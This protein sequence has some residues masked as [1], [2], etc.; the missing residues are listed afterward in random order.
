MNT[1]Q[2]EHILRLRC[3][4]QFL[5]VYP[6]DKLPKT[7]PPKRPLIL[8]CNTDPHDRPGQH[9]IVI[10]IDIHSVGEHFDSFGQRPAKTFQDFMR[11]HCFKWICNQRQIQSAASRFCG[12]YCVF[13]SL[14][15][16]IGYNMNAIV[17]CFSSDT[18][19]ND[20]MAHSFV[21]KMF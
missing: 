17:K 7:L 2:I 16:S 13:Y 18:G 10:F 19:L 8:V 3:R 5:G 6:I 11:Y 12:Q 9:W 21:C 15:K 14:Y 20:V 4:G 1:G